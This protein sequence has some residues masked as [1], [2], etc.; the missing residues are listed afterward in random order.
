MTPSETLALLKYFDEQCGRTVTHFD[1]KIVKDDEYQKIFFV[2]YAW[3]AT[4]LHNFIS[5][6]KPPAYQGENI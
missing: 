5:F 2:A 1:F 6:S 4:V 3:P